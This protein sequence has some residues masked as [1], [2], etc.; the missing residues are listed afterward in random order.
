MNP[1]PKD[2]N[3]FVNETE[4]MSSLSLSRRIAVAHRFESGLNGTPIDLDKAFDIFKET[5]EKGSAE[6]LYNTGRCYGAGIGTSV[7]L[8]KMMECYKAAAAQKPFVKIP[9]SPYLFENLGVAAAYN[10]IGNSYRDGRG[11][12]VDY[13]IAFEHYL[14]AGELE[15]AEAQNNLGFF[16]Y[17]GLGVAKNLVFARDWY[18]K[19]A[20]QGLAEAEF[21]YAGMLQKGE[22]F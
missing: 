6:G 4:F 21:N 14:R 3:V 15:A 20:E 13:K 5:G 10:G 12:D 16:L 7:D 1:D 22:G 8:I 9:Y 19:A 17:K 2:V 18:K 11:V